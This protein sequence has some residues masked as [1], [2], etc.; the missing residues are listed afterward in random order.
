MKTNVEE[1]FTRACEEHSNALFRYCCFKI[2][3]REIAKDL[4]QETYMKAWIYITK[5]EEVRNIRA[6]FY[7]ILSNL[8]IDQYK[9][10]KTLS[11][12]ALSKDGFE[13]AFNEK[14]DLENRLDGA[15]ALKMLNQIPE[16][17][18]EVIF[19]RYVQDMSLQEISQI[20]KEPEN[21]IAVKVHRGLKKVAEIFNRS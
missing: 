20:T 15:I 11:L 16:M 19:M 3:D 8:I 7:K 6:F 1:E 21:T 9:K 10:K 5:G 12:D 14:D 4:V 18:R 2:S 13:P 17:Y